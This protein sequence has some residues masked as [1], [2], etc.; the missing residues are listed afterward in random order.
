MYIN[1]FNK[2]RCFVSHE[3]VL[4][5]GN[6][7]P[8]EF[9]V[10]T[11]CN[12]VC[13]FLCRKYILLHLSMAHWNSSSWT[14]PGRKILFVPKLLE[15]LTFRAHLLVFPVFLAFFL[16]VLLYVWHS[17]LYVLLSQ[18]SNQG[19]VG[20]RREVPGRYCLWNSSLC[21][22]FSGWGGKSILSEVAFCG[23]T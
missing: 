22:I 12:S 19:R 2:K 4:W 3:L 5:A 1:P 21:V 15:I 18:I 16:Y 9:I 11:A 14:W 20:G 17:F 8:F 7:S 23:V 13:L 10:K 6:F